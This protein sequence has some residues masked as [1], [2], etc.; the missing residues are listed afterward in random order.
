MAGSA[1]LEGLWH[2]ALDTVQEYGNGVLVFSGGRILGGDAGYYYT[3]HY[4]LE[5]EALVLTLQ[6]SH[7]PHQ[8]PAA[9]V[10]EFS[11]EV[12]GPLGAGNMT[13]T[14]SVLE[15][16]SRVTLQLTRLADWP[17]EPTAGRFSDRGTTQA[18]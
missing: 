8:R 17:S 2:L 4:R 14:G 15:M 12:E 16:P 18:W 10:Q 9:H 1:E 5:G 13:L 11:L 3:G 6:G 7:Y